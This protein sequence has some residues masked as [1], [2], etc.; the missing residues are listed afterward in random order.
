MD[1]ANSAWLLRARYVCHQLGL[2]SCT[3]LQVVHVQ[4]H[5]WCSSSFIYYHNNCISS[6]QPSFIHQPCNVGGERAR[7]GFIGL[8]H[9]ACCMLYISSYNSS[10]CIQQ[11]TSIC[12]ILHVHLHTIMLACLLHDMPHRAT[13]APRPRPFACKVLLPISHHSQPACPMLCSLAGD[14][15]MCSASATSSSAPL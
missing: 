6:I 13:C 10:A 14:P 4:L 12:A 3:L 7:L 11:H 1:G 2:A 15:Y 9:A 5:A 8:Q